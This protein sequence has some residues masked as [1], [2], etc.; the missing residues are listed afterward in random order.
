[1]LTILSLLACANRAADFRPVVTDV[2]AIVDL[3]TIETIPE[4]T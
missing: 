4:S 1:M 2:P 3:G